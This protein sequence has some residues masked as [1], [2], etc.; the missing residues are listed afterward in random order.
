MRK[1]DFI[2]NILRVPLDVAMLLGAG[3]ATY[4]LRTQVLD[5]LRP[6]LFGPNLSFGQFMAMVAGMTVVMVGTFAISGLY[7]MKFR[8]SKVAEVGRVLVASSAAMMSAILVIFLRAE[9]FH[10]RFL[11]LGY[12][13]MAMLCVALGRLM[14][15]WYASRRMWQVDSLSHRVLL[16]GSGDVAREVR[17]AMSDNPG[18]GY[19]VVSVM[20]TLDIDHLR[21]LLSR[22]GIDEVVLAD[23]EIGSD[24]IVE[25]VDLCYESHVMFQ[26]VPNAYQ[27][28]ATHY[29]VNSVGRIPLVYLRRTPLEGW[30]R[31]FKRSI[32]IVCSFVALILLAP[33]F[34]VVA[35][36]IMLDT[37]GPVFVVLRRV[38]RNRTFGLIKF[39]SMVENAEALKP[40]L[41]QFNERSDGPLFKM[42]HDPRVTRVGRVLRRYR[43][44]ELPQFVNV[45]LGDISLVGP[46][47]HQP[48]EIA[49]YQKHHKKVLAI[50][51]GATGLAQASGSSD[52]SFE[53]E[54]ALD[55]FYIENWSF[56][57]DVRIVAK[58][59]LRLLFDRSAV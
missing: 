48:D 51:A 55:T 10:S 16:I 15:R 53:E 42:R 21:E 20:G 56:W 59:A 14:L 11:V 3:I 41:E 27:T 23:V 29:D 32:D 22:G 2:F 12:W 37:S 17:T 1:A 36:C 7:S 30:G 54:V 39:R 47:P 28:L 38:S 5:A 58:T 34:V 8:M 45:F 4:L 35:F 19:R 31:V 49:R 25:L 46:R 57:M 6:V 18:L 24:R 40:A 9:L 13:G 43:I 33:V 44:D 26:F 50:K 52:L